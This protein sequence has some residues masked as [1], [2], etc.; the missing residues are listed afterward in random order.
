MDPDWN[1][2][3]LSLFVHG[4]GQEEKY[5]SQL[6]THFHLDNDD[7]CDNKT[8]VLPSD[9]NTTSM[10]LLTSL[11]LH[12]NEHPT[13]LQQ[14]LALVQYVNTGLKSCRSKKTVQKEGDNVPNQDKD[15]SDMIVD[16]PPG[17]ILFFKLFT[18]LKDRNVNH[19]CLRKMYTSLPKTLHALPPLALSPLVFRQLKCFSAEFAISAGK[20]KEGIVDQML[21]AIRESLQT[22]NASNNMSEI[23]QLISAYLVLSMKSG[24]LSYLLQGVMLCLIDLPSHTHSLSHVSASLQEI[25]QA[26]ALEPEVRKIS[27][28]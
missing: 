7:T 4:E 2:L 16:A 21:S 23:S 8:L 13:Y 22:S 26:Q 12:Q 18:R 19:P 24:Q 20:K 14:R 1:A 5:V 27:S 28:I 17:S 10:D 6:Y 9:M 25:A 11:L 15:N 3:L